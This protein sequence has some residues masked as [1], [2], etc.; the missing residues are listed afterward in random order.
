GI[1]ITVWVRRR[2]RKHIQNVHVSAVGVG[3][4]GYIGNKGSISETDAVKRNADVH[5]IHKRTRFNT[6]SNSKRIENHDRIIWLGDLNY[7]LNLSYEKTHDL[8]SKKNWSRLLEGDQLDDWVLCRVYNKKNNNPKEMIIPQEDNRI[9]HSHPDLHPTLPLDE[10]H[11]K[12]GVSN[13]SDSV[14]SFEYSNGEFGVKSIVT[15]C[16]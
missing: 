10:V 5:E 7:R 12:N 9:R 14:G 2:L 15:L 3:V 11:S 16:F 4:M 13:N 8:I 6:L 1:F